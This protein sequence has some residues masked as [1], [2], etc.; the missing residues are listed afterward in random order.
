[1]TIAPY[2]CR[3][4]SVFAAATSEPY[5]KLVHVTWRTLARLTICDD[6]EA[7]SSIGHVAVSI[8]KTD[9]ATHFHI[10]LLCD[11]SGDLGLPRISNYTGNV[12]GGCVTAYKLGCEAPILSKS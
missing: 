5:T 4:G 7:G 10:H 3:L 8:L 2:A 1:M 9:D 11:A 12:N 6:L